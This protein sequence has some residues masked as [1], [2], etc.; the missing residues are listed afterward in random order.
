MTNL[1]RAKFEEA[2]GKLDADREQTDKLGGLAN[3]DEE[4]LS[5]RFSQ[6]IARSWLL[7]DPIGVE[8][9]TVLLDKTLGDDSTAR[10]KEVFQKHGF[11]IDEFFPH[12]V[13][14]IVVD[15]SSFFSTWTEQT[16]T[17]TLP[18]PPRPQEVTDAQLTAWVNNDDPNITE[19]PY[20]YI[21]YTCL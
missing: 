9:R 3:R 16:K 5:K 6:L 21:P 2:D 10:I 1:G 11:D 14:N 15:W 19:P 20:P 13:K 17:V 4:N 7:S 18:Y 8:I 12:E